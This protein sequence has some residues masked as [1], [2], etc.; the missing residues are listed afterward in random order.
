MKS[1]AKI[2]SWLSLV[3]MMIPVILFLTGS[4][5]KL[6][7]VKI[8]MNICTVIWFATASVWMWNSDSKQ[9]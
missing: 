8:V 6:D 1:V 2:V 9:A 3:A 4:G 7:T 5:I